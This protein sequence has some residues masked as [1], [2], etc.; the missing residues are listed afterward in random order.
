MK[1][2]NIQAIIGGDAHTFFE[3]G[4]NYIEMIYD[5]KENLKENIKNGVFNQSSC[6]LYAHHVTKMVRVMK[7]IGRGEFCELYRNVR[8][9]CK[10]KRN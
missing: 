8:K 1:K 3:I 4:R 2:L 7:M 5:N 6:I 9:K 10:R